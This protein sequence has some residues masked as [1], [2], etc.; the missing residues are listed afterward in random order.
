MTVKNFYNKDK[1]RLYVLHFPGTGMEYEDSRH[2]IADTLMLKFSVSEDIEIISV[3]DEPCWKHSILRKQCENNGIKILNPAINEKNWNNTKKIDYIL[4]AL[5]QTK[6][7]YCL[8]LDGRD[9]QI[10][11]SLD[12]EF[13]E[14]FKRFG[15][16]IVYN[17]TPNAYPPVVIEPIQEVIAIKGKQKYLNAGVCLGE[18]DSLIN[19]YLKAADINKRNPDNH[20]EQMIIRMARKNFPEYA[21]HDTNNDIFRIIH[22]YDTKMIEVIDGYVLV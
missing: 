13:I 22:A 12:N 14:K 4:E 21:T 2:I 15:K 6:K 10:C 19:F 1:G 16:P 7:Q 3:M 20:S 5:R 17:G 9:V 8:I 11:A 18:R